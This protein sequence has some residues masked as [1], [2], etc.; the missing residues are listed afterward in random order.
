MTSSSVNSSELKLH[1]TRVLVTGGASGIGKGT[2]LRLAQLGARVVLADLS[3]AA[4]DQACSEVGAVAAVAGHL[5]SEADCQA[6]LATTIARCGGID[7]LV[8]AAGISDKV[9]PATELDINEW[10]RVVDVNLRGNFLIARTVGRALI[11]QGKGAIVNISSAYGVMGVP[12]RSAYGPAKAAVAMLTRNLACEWGM[13]GVR[14]NGIVPGYIATPMIERLRDEGKL[15]VARLEARTPMHRLGTPEE[16]GN[17]AAF[18]ISDMAS[19]VTG[20]LLAVDGGWTAY[21]GP[22]AGTTP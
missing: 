10:Q 13:T 12:C 5:T 11:A 17:A 18:L 22:G 1:G 21:G 4:L 3:G 19:Y 7:A 15:D 14:V 20:A 8:N 16:V 6:M 2:A 9:V